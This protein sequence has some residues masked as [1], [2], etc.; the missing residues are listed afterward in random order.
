MAN[1][2]VMIDLL[3]NPKTA[4][5]GLNEL[6][7]YLNK[8]Q[9]SAGG[10]STAKVAQLP[11]EAKSRL[12]D[13][14]QVVNG[15]DTA[16][17]KKQ[18]QLL[19]RMARERGKLLGLAQA[20]LTV[21]AKA[22]GKQASSIEV[23]KLKK[24]SS[25]AFATSLGLDAL[26][27]AI[28][29]EFDKVAQQTRLAVNKAVGKLSGV[30]AQ[31]E[32]RTQSNQILNEVGVT[33]PTRVRSAARVA[34]ETPRRVAGTPTPQQERP[35][36]VRSAK[37]LDTSTSDSRT[38]K[39]AD[40]NAKDAE[41]S[42]A[43]QKASRQRSDKA[44]AAKA[45]SDE[46]AAKLSSQREK[47][48]ERAAKKAEAGLGT[49]SKVESPKWR[50]NFPKEQVAAAQKNAEKL[51]ATRIPVDALDDVLKNG[52]KTQF[53]DIR[54][55]G[56]NSKGARDRTESFW[57]VPKDARPD[58]RPKY[59]FLADK[60]GLSKTSGYGQVLLNLELDPGQVSVTL[61]DSG[62]DVP[63]DVVSLK[64]FKEKEYDDLARYSNPRDDYIETQM[65]GNIGREQIKSVE[66]LPEAMATKA[67]LNKLLDVADVANRAGLPLKVTQ[68]PGDILEPAQNTQQR[69]SGVVEA[70]KAKGLDIEL[71]PLNEAVERFGTKLKSV[72][73]L[74]SKAL[75]PIYAEDAAKIPSQVEGFQ[76]DIDQDTRFSKAKEAEEVKQV[77]AEKRVTKATE[78]EAQ[79]LAAKTSAAAQAPAQTA[80]PQQSLIPEQ[81]PVKDINAETMAKLKALQDEYLQ[82]WKKKVILERAGQE[83]RNKVYQIEKQIE[84]TKDQERITALKALRSREQSIQKSITA[85]SRKVG[86]A[87]DSIREEAFTLPDI[88]QSEKFMSNYPARE[89]FQSQAGTLERKAREQLE[90]EAGLTKGV[91]TNFDAEIEAELK[92][93]LGDEKTLTNLTETE[94][95]IRRRSVG[96]ELATTKASRRRA[97]ALKVDEVIPPTPRRADIVPT[98]PP[99]VIEAQSVTKAEKRRIVQGRGQERADY[100]ARGSRGVDPIVVDGEERKALE[101][102]TRE[103]VASETQAD[104]ATRGAA[105]LQ[106]LEAL[107]AA[108][109]AKQLAA[110]RQITAVVEQEAIDRKTFYSRGG[111]TRAETNAAERER[112]AGVRADQGDYVKD[113][114]DQYGP[115]VV[116]EAKV[117]R[118]A[119]F[120]DFRQGLQQQL[121]DV[122]EDFIKTYSGGLRGDVEKVNPRTNK[123]YK[124]REDPL[125]EVRRTVQDGLAHTLG[126]EYDFIKSDLIEAYAPAPGRKGVKS[127]R[128]RLFE[129]Y[130]KEFSIGL[131]SFGDP[132]LDS[133]NPEDM[134]QQLQQI[135][136][137]RQQVRAPN[138]AQP[139]LGT[140]AARIE[141]EKA[142]I[143]DQQQKARLAEAEKRQRAYENDDRQAR[144]SD[145]TER[146]A[147]R[148]IPD[149][150]VRK[151]GAFDD[152]ESRSLLAAANSQMA[153]EWTE[154]VA[155]ERVTTAAV[156]SVADT[157]QTRAVLNK[158]ITAAQAKALDIINTTPGI[159]SDELRNRGVR[160]ST[161]T[162]LQEKGLVSRSGEQYNTTNIADDEDGLVSAL[163][164]KIRALNAQATVLEN[165]LTPFTVAENELIKALHNKANA[166]N[167]QTA[168]SKKSNPFDAPEPSKKSK[169]GSSGDE[170]SEP[171]KQP[172]GIPFPNVNEDFDPEDGWNATQAAMQKVNAAWMQQAT[173]LELYNTEI[174]PLMAQQFAAYQAVT[175]ALTKQLA[176]ATMMDIAND[177]NGL[178]AMYAQGLTD[179][180][181]ADTELRGLSAEQIAG[182]PATAKRLIEAEGKLAGLTNEEATRRAEHILKSP[183]LLKSEIELILVNQK[184]A[185]ARAALLN[186]P[187]FRDNYIGSKVA[188]RAPKFVL[189]TDV[190]AALG[191]REDVKDA[192][193]RRRV[194]NNTA[195]AETTRRVQNDPALASEDLAAAVSLHLSRV[196]SSS[197][198]WLQIASYSSVIA[199]DAAEEKAARDKLTKA[200]NDEYFMRKASN[201]GL[202][203]N[204]ATGRGLADVE[205]LEEKA[206]TRSA[207]ADDDTLEARYVRSQVDLIEAN[208]KLAAKVEALA[209][210]TPSILQSRLEKVTAQRTSKIDL[211]EA[212]LATPE[213]QDEVRRRAALNQ[214]RR[215]LTGTTRETPYQKA[216]ANPGEFFGGGALSSLRYGLPSMLLYGAGSGLMNTIREAEELQVALAKLESQFN[217]VFQGQDFAP[218]RQQILDVAQDTG[219]AADEIANLQIQITGAFSGKDTKGKQI[220]I[221]GDSGQVLVEKQ[222]ASAAKLAQTV[223]LPLAEITDG[224]TAASLAF[225]T[226]FEKIGDV[227]LA[228]E[229]E[230]GVLAKETISFIGDIAP[231]AQ[232]AG[233]SL[234]EFA[235]IAAVAQQRSGRSGAALAESFGRVIPA[236]T[237]QKDKL[238]ELASIAP[239]LG[240]DEF[241]DAIRSSDPK[242]ILDAIGR[243]YA[244]L[245]KEAQQ[246]IVTL[247]GGRREAQA[248]IPAL[249][250]QGLTDRLEDV[251]KNSAG[252]LDERFQK[253]KTTIT[254]TLQR[255]TELVRQVGVELLEAGF[256]DAF[257]NA[258]KGAKLFLNILTPV[259]KIIS[260]INDA[261][262]GLPVQILLGVA[263]LKVM[264]A[265]LTKTAADGTTSL[266][267]GRVTNSIFGPQGLL[268]NA[269][270]GYSGGFKNNFRQGVLQSRGISPTSAA[271]Q[272]LRTSSL[273]GSA[274]L[275]G[276]IKATGRGAL[277]VLGGGSVAL[278]AGFVGITALAALYGK[279]NSEIDK[280]EAQL[281]ELRDEIEQGNENIDLEDVD[282]RSDRIAD[283]TAR[284]ESES[285]R[286]E[287]WYEGWNGFL[288]QLGVVQSKAEILATEAQVLENFDTKT[289]EFFQYADTTTLKATSELVRPKLGRPTGNFRDAITGSGGIF[290]SE[291][292][293]KF[294]YDK[295]GEIRRDTSETGAEANQ[296]KLKEDEQRFIEESARLAGV[297]VPELDPRI[298]SLLLDPGNNPGE[299]IKE[300]AEGNGKYAEYGEKFVE[301]AGVVR[302]AFA[303][304]G[305]S[306]KE[307]ANFIES[308]KGTDLS[309]I[310]ANALNLEQIKAAFDVGVISFDE[311]ARRLREKLDQRRQIL[312]SGDQTE[313]SELEMLQVAQQEAELN[314]QLSES[315]LAGQERLQAIDDAYGTGQ[316]NTDARTLMVNLDNLNNPNFQDKDLRL[317]AA[318]NV[319][320]AQKRIDIDLA[321]ATGSID[322]VLKVLNE[323]SKVNAT[324][325]SVIAFNQLEQSQT[326]KDA[327]GELIKAFRYLFDLDVTSADIDKFYQTIFTDV[328]D[329]GALN[330]ENSANLQTRLDD[331]IGQINAKGFDPDSDAGEAALTAFDSFIQLLN[332]SGVSREKL[333][334]ALKRNS[335]YANMTPE[336]LNAELDAILSAQIL[337][338]P[339]AVAKAN[340]DTALGD[341][342]DAF[343]PSRTSAESN[344]VAQALY[345]KQQA[346]AE[347][348]YLK[349]PKNGATQK[350]INDAIQKQQEAENELAAAFAS[351]ASSMFDLAATEQ[352][353]AGDIVGSI[354][355]EIAAI[356]VQIEAAAA[357]QDWVAVNN[358]NAQ[359]A[360]KYEELRKQYVSEANAVSQLNAGLAT[361][362]GDLVGAALYALQEAD[363]NV[364]AARSPEEK[365]SALLA[366]AQARDN[367]RKQ[368]L[369]DQ[370]APYSVFAAYLEGEGD[371]LNAAIT[372]QKEAQIRLDNAKGPQERAAAEVAKLAA[373]QQVRQERATIRD[374]SY[375][376]FSSEIA[377]NDPVA[378]AKVAEALA[379]QQLKDARGVVEKAN[380]QV[381]LNNAQKALND[382]M[383]EA[384]YSVYNLRQA[385]L[386]AMD[387]D[388]GAAQLA[389]EL[390]RI[391]LN[392]AIKAGAGTAAINQLRG[393]VITADKAARDMV[394]NEKLDEYKWLLDMGQ[395]TQSQYIKYLESLQSTLAPGSKQFKDL[396][397]TIKQLKDGISSDL[398]ANL[399]TSLRLP[400]LYEVRRFDQTGASSGGATAGIGYQDNRQVSIQIEVNNA[401]QDTQGIVLQTIEEALGTGRNGYGSRRYG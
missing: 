70:L 296:I 343:T 37:P 312:A 186:S 118:K 32:F 276:G 195:R 38:Q 155:Y 43:S 110:E 221:G 229:Q 363:N 240:G 185:A 93:Q 81:R 168:A 308:A 292:T 29:K 25:A 401:D 74:P 208:N 248:L 309:P 303:D 151:G 386:Q 178:G 372:R 33:K 183:Q 164:R 371:S 127:D 100:F 123:K 42:A 189:D 331:V 192:R 378:Q 52:L 3:V 375:A 232:E 358:L 6:E 258:L 394:I 79:I 149:A 235:S 91:K 167:N 117:R 66:F 362:N 291:G 49:T 40:S 28:Q 366:Q 245:N 89:I 381:N 105:S 282:L 322:E 212:Y 35:K 388:V 256:A 226:S 299:L 318:L 289:N 205:K 285:K 361:I 300:A 197:A 264:Q 61:G 78:K 95:S 198:K 399:P 139:D 233:Y 145:D 182:D 230:S 143:A 122:T 347:L 210:S 207:I 294:V 249:A 266:I 395:I 379:R 77:A 201:E 65:R 109:A 345:A 76:K 64:D 67:D 104:V 374:A 298:V 15:K 293:K 215:Q 187:Q 68:Q 364:N 301:Q 94:V 247:L 396:A 163:Q 144:R 146:R 57:G 236:I 295:E 157:Q 344:S 173:L 60:K 188:E 169:R 338:D 134:M 391:Q 339:A 204:A 180:R 193:A 254:N 222:V 154:Q 274:G 31:K 141:Q 275:G 50:G 150:P 171:R 270:A 390:A 21:A 22:A 243:S 85:E 355:S 153:E 115:Q 172:D 10:S 14:K 55:Q 239:S 227:A 135:E 260:T 108:E 121:D 387:D 86:D 160:S 58:Q 140:Y 323:G 337:P 194:Q 133:L 75:A 98:A 129:K 119:E 97:E 107:E 132:L 384:R 304:A 200:I 250:N 179:T 334:E 350:E 267:G 246:T 271:G 113:L 87:I 231:V 329:D 351:A 176:G 315:V 62:S 125:G 48:G 88:D 383:N 162:S 39:A 203:P 263:A 2:K 106:Q 69:L 18:E 84:V 297:K 336:Q 102:K 124:V 126:A 259:A 16:E 356:D 116:K 191:D 199:T 370:L 99:P 166:L 219:L 272:S 354:N 214:Q 283:L 397:L 376:L 13:T 357:A 8:L 392:D 142:D 332:F 136:T 400:T 253:I 220:S 340:R 181:I 80:A 1:N 23:G 56:G 114:E 348:A 268:Q 11:R 128:L 90:Q 234:E 218:V 353:I 281:Q 319:I 228:I 19:M 261:F 328:F 314:K 211:E 287:E 120:P 316:N 170:D 223:G 83:S 159:T 280:S 335:Q 277:S 137:L 224:L 138:K 184:V 321:L 112:R 385:E 92:K 305:Y 255:I 213:G 82:T 302:K 225:D 36:K 30:A 333:L 349:D 24:V 63:S 9:R 59:G 327:R 252:T 368:Q 365:A 342:N 148:D 130:S 46:R 131:E 326:F 190:Q 96:S 174:Q 12:L 251:A 241:V 202:T 34:A 320:E 398:Q 393:Q 269:T 71:T 278:G 359:K 307:I 273:L 152:A 237:E 165:K 111:R 317:Q 369:E 262:G 44:L 310:E 54:T 257:L 73:D 341:I 290:G 147:I 288:I 286:V 377:G 4:K 244:G 17:L 41:R 279:V 20:E 325:R 103:R 101:A 242:A 26:P 5:A 175:L 158:K 177:P 53:E 367:L 51:L 27:V 72:T 47:S 284:A 324:A 380:A 346:D 161:L 330:A 265:L 216:K 238:L 306:D 7:S 206:G 196:Q 313:A 360:Q 156:K 352:R 209:A 217:A 382:A 45:A 389:A 373:D 311:Y